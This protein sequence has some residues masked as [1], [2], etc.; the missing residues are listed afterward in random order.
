[1]AFWNPAHWIG[2]LALSASVAGRGNVVADSFVRFH[3][4]NYILVD[5]PAKFF[6]HISIK[7]AVNT[8]CVNL[9]VADPSSASIRAFWSGIE[10]RVYVV[11]FV[12]ASALA[13]GIGPM[14][15][16]RAKFNR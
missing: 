3:N 6:R 7:G 5:R 15:Q 10:F 9:L 13:K 12:H 8:N 4:R 16:S 2:Y 14:F 1:M 11:D